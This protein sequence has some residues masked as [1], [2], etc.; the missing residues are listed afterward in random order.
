MAFKKGQPNPNAGRPA[1]SPNKATLK[2]REA[3]SA[4]VDGNSDRVQGWLDEIYATKGAEAALNAFHGFLEFHV[5]KLART[6][7]TGKDG[8]DIKIQSSDVTQ[9][10]LQAIPQ[11]QLESLLSEKPQ[12]NA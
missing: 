11:E 4:F 7:L 8:E 12:D 2:A 3:I 1:G 10:V 5:P 6:E 9:R